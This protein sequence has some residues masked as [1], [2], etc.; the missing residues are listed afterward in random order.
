M[1]KN[2][3]VWPEMYRDD[4]KLT[5]IAGNGREWPEMDGDGW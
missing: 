1:T 2:G 5:G 4:R 3:L